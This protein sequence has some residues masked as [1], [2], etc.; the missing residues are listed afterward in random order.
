[1]K[2]RVLVVDDSPV[3]RRIF[4][5]ELRRD[6]E[7]E[8]VG[9]APDPYAARDMIVELRPDVLTLDI[10]MP[11]MDG[12]TFL[13]KLMRYFP[14][15]VIVI[16]SASPRGGDLAL[17]A[18]D[19]GAVE[20]ISK[21][22]D[23]ASFADFAVQLADKVKA[24]ARIRMPK[25]GAAPTP[26]PAPAPAPH[27]VVPAPAALPPVSL[28]RTYNRII[29]IGASTGGTVAIEKILKAMPAGAPA[30]VIVQHM[31]QQF[32]KA[33]A[34]RLNRLCAIEVKEASDGDDVI[35][36]R[37]LIAP[38]GFHMLLRKN[39]AGYRV[40]VKLGPLVC[41]QRPSVDVLFNSV[42]QAAGR[43]AVGVILT[44]MGNDG[45]QGM[46]EMRHAGALNIA[47]DEASCVVFGMPREAIELGAADHIL[48]LDQ[49][50]RLMLDLASRPR[51]AGTA[52]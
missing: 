1:M 18:M 51:A 7:I 44:G 50:P 43:N 15:P 31:P 10:E 47:Q 33:F 6:P 26:I 45:A 30:I 14:L 16:S 20:L 41:R 25:P 46:L 19:A 39:Q 52:K 29:A 35:P 21:P 49:I 12:I 32:T 11:R 22:R 38:G 17:A 9:A 3:V 27:P 13:K 34:D 8:V 37:A 36:G 4:Q 2:I 40:Q 48:P 42:A 24:A 23:E 5:E 28:S